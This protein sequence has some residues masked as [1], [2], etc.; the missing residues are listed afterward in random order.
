[1]AHDEEA[2]PE[3]DAEPAADM[4]A[5]ADAGADQAGP[6]IWA[7]P[8]S[9]TSAGYPSRGGDAYMRLVQETGYCASLGLS[10]PAPGAPAIAANDQ[11][12]SRARHEYH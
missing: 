6:S 7:H 8:T 3:A 10:W 1:M 2:A 5:A 11:T 9:G 4:S 12:G